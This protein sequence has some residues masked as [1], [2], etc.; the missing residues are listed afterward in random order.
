MSKVMFSFPNQL[1]T[2]MKAAIPARERSK[3]LAIL[4]EKE[5]TVREQYLY[6]CAKELEESK[7]LKDE[8]T[9]WDSEFGGD[10]LDDV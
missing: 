7:S 8:I 6:T 2:R 4:L 10:G 3:V 1:V 5:I 9:G